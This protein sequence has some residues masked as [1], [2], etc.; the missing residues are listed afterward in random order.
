MALK[1]K[2]STPPSSVLIL[3]AGLGKRMKSSLPKVL[4]LIGGEPILFKILETVKKVSPEAEIGLV[5]GHGKKEVEDAVR[6]HAEF[7][8]MKISFIIQSEQ[9]GTGHATRIALDSPWG[10]KRISEG[11]NVLVLPGDLPLL[12]EDLISGML[13]PMGTDSIRLL[14]CE[15]SDPTG[16]GRVIR[17]GKST[18]EKI[19]EEKDAKPAQKKVREV[20]ASIYTFRSD[21]LARALPKLTTNNSQGEYYLTDLISLGFKTKKKTSIFSWS[22]EEDV[23]GINDPWELSLAEKILRMR[24][25]EKWARAGV[26]FSAPDATWIEATVELSEGVQVGPGVVLEGITQIGKNTIIGAHVVLKS[27][28]VGANVEIKA[29][30]VCEQSV[31][32]DGAKIGPYAHLRPESQVGKN[33]KIGNFVE[34]K[35]SSIGADTSISHLSYLGDA[36]VGSRVNIGCGFVTCNF[37]GRTINGSRKHKTII[38]DDAFIGSACQVVAPIKIG[39][40]SYLA[41]GSTITKD[42]GADDLG[43]A[44][45]RQENKV[46]Y[47]KRLKGRS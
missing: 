30:S 8:K 20:A 42:V 16:Y 17:R 9:K 26:K 22:N 2:K 29:G 12:T 32:L 19:V 25:I 40:G 36:E 37:D 45:S 14:T 7:S 35:K 47:A 33:S 18:V 24:T 28:I 39:K 1:Q 44:R 27:T 23:R 10:K 13:E 6:G 11:A 41:S 3:A 43:I 34:L 5:L 15:L 38:E 46:G 4:H 31:I 21:F